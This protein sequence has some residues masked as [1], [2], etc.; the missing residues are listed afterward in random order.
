M[1]NYSFQLNLVYVL[2]V[3]YLVSG[4]SVLAACTHVQVIYSIIICNLDGF[5]G[6]Q[7]S[8]KQNLKHA[9]VDGV[10]ISLSI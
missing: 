1:W 5:K 7:C 10:I 3:L 9:V 2:V 8:V 6:I 4:I